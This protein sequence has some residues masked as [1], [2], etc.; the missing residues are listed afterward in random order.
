MHQSQKPGVLEG[1]LVGM[2]LLVSLA[3]A[4]PWTRRQIAALP[5]SA[6]AAVEVTAAGKKIRHL[7]HHT[8]TGALDPAHLLN[9]LAR[10]PQVQW[11]D[12]GKREAAERHLREH[13]QAYRAGRVAQSRVAFPLHLNSASVSELMALPFIGRR[14]ADAI[15]A[16]RTQ[17]QGFSRVEE[18]KQ[19]TGIGPVIFEPIADL[20][21]VP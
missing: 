21:T 18:L 3:D 2:L 13:L 10:L 7:P 11:V 6:F 16:Y 9:A 14:R 17:R 8:P 5:D 19:V 4:A 12:P 20:V 15:L 1:V